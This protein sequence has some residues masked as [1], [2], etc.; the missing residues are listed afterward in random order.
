M[1]TDD[2]GERHYLGDEDINKGKADA[3]RDVDK[4]CD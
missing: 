1:T 4:F 2:K 3:Q